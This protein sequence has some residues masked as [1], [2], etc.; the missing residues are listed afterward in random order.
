M[1]IYE[2]LLIKRAYSNQSYISV[3]AFSPPA[4]E[5]LKRF[6]FKSKESAEVKQKELDSAREALGS[7]EFYTTLSEIEVLD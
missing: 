7:L 5:T 2:L 6:F 1:K 4:N 3:T